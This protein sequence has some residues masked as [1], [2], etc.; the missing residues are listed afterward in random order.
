[1]AVDDHLQNSP[2][3]IGL[4]LDDTYHKSNEVRL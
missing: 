4:R 2:E 1:M 3:W